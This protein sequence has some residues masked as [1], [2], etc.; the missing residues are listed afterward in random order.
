[1]AMLAGCFCEPRETT[2]LTARDRGFILPLSP[3]SRVAPRIIPGRLFFCAID[4]QS[5]MV[6]T[7]V[8]FM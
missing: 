5:R 8:K 2:G 3:Q 1:M 6:K 7:K 4:S